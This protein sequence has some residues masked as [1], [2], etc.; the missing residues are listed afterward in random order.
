MAFL[1]LFSVGVNTREGDPVGGFDEAA[2]VDEFGVDDAGLGGAEG[3]GEAGAGFAVI[4]GE[5]LVS[6]EESVPDGNALFGEHAGERGDGA[7]MRPG[8]A[9][10]AGFAG[11]DGE[12]DGSGGGVAGEVVGDGACVG[13]FLAGLAGEVDA[14]GR[15]DAVLVQGDA[16]QTF[17]RPEAQ[18][19][20]DEAENIRW[21]CDRELFHGPGFPSPVVLP[22]FL[23]LLVVGVV[24]VGDHPLG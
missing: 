8:L 16:D 22:C 5:G 7:G 13:E 9:V 10:L 1:A 3:Q 12:E 15:A 14:Q 18:G 20:P 11:L 2:A 4:G 21:C 19:V 17:L 6:D 23:R 24:L